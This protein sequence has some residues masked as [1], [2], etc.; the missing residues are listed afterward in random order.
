MSPFFDWAKIGFFHSTNRRTVISNNF[1]NIIK[2]M[3]ISKGFH[4]SSDFNEYFNWNCAHCCCWD[5]MLKRHWQC[6]HSIDVICFYFHSFLSPSSFY[7]TRFFFAVLFSLLLSI[8]WSTMIRLHFVCVYAYLIRR[9]ELSMSE[10]F[11]ENF[12]QFWRSIKEQNKMVNN[13]I[14]VAKKSEWRR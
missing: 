14:R 13:T 2:L 11:A 9:W 6:S 3:C 1:N 4:C 7:C 10:T 12:P 5:K 8:F